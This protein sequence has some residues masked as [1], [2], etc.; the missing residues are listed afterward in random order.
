M[1]HNND[2]VR[3]YH[4]AGHAVIARVLGVGVVYITL[5]PSDETNNGG[6]Q[7]WS[8]AW[9]ARATG[10]AAALTRGFETDAKVSLAGPYAQ[11]KHRPNT[12]MKRASRD[13]WDSDL[14]N[15]KSCAAT[16]VWLQDHADEAGMTLSAEQATEALR[17]FQ[18]LQ[19]EARALVEEHWPSV[20]RVAKALLKYRALQGG[21]VDDLIGGRPIALT[22]GSIA[23][24]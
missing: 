10:D 1:T 6:A 19:D 4:E 7:T 18:R 22:L 17:I 14:G 12:N 9:L 13:E 23:S 8:A 24:R 16:M 21:E 20:E 3:A 15:A 2:E 11:I 5:F